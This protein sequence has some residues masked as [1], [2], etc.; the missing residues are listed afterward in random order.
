[1]KVK[2]EKSF[3]EQKAEREANKNTVDHPLA[4]GKKLDMSRGELNSFTKA[5][6]KQEFRAMLDD[7]VDE[8]SDPRYKPEMK[9]YLRQME[10][11]GDL[12]PGTALIE[13]EAG[14]CLKTTSKKLMND[15]NKTFFDQKTFI[16]VCFH[17]KVPKA[18]K[19][20]TTGPDGK[21][22]YSWS[23]PYRVSKQRHDQDKEK[24]LVSTFD[25]IFNDDIKQYMVY[26]DFQ[27]FVSDTAI[28]GI[29]RVLAEN[30]EKISTDYK[31]MKNLKCK[32]GEPALMTIKLD[33][34]ENPLLKNMD[35]TKAK[36]GLQKELEKK[37]SAHLDKLEKE[38]MEKKRLEEAKRTFEEHDEES[39]EEAEEERPTGIVQPK[40]K[41]VH[42]Y[43][44]DIGGAWGG[45]QTSKMQHETDM[46][47]KVPQG[48][49]VTI[50][51]KWV[52]SIKNAKLDINETSLVFEYP[53]LYY[54]D[55]N[56][57]YKVDS[58]AGKA[59]FDKAK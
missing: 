1:M 23:L 31:I 29:S 24:N 11:Q 37:R 3:E 54:L 44:A 45:F 58:E 20:P 7:Y 14:Y 6:E 19:I 17:P 25:V 35:I 12:P 8:I 46:K 9:Q 27:K 10:E 28:D 42:S 32:G 18:E 36:P 21:P 49:S 34:T 47:S 55:L 43:D 33:E 59:K 40:Y 51:L 56:L 16:N 15:K 38:E 2:S 22:G 57:K 52:D 48:L 53:E 4:E 41:I 50:N 30:K 39:E 13:P 26:P 5:M